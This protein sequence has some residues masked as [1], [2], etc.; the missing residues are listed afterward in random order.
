MLGGESGRPELVL[1]DIRCNPN[2]IDYNT[3][4]PKQ[5]IPPP[6]KDMFPVFITCEVVVT[7]ME[8]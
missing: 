2:T 1:N 5:K 6:F 7:N 3:A 8:I 4:L